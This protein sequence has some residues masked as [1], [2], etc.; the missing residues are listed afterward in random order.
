M[1]TLTFIASLFCWLSCYPQPAVSGLPFDTPALQ[2]LSQYKEEIMPT[3]INGKFY[4]VNVKTGKKAFV[5]GFDAAY[6]FGGENFAIVKAAGK[7]G[8]INK[9]GK[10][11]VSP[12]YKSFKICSPMPWD[13]VVT[14]DSSNDLLFDLDRGKFITRAGEIDPYIEPVNFVTFKGDDSRFGLKKIINNEYYNQKTLFE[15][16]FDSVYILRPNY[17]VAAR[18]GTIGIADGE[19]ITLLP[20]EY[21]E[22]IS[23]KPDESRAVKLIGLR[24]ATEWEYYRLEQKPELILRSAHQCVSL[25][26][27]TIPGALGV[28][29]SGS[30][31]NVLFR[32]GTLLSKDY[33]WI[34]NDATIAIDGNDVYIIGGDGDP[35]FYYK[36]P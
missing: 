18:E 10:Y 16:V 20:F 32:T 6:P 11:T 15:P 4:Y 29:K 13:H 21:D 17:F 31:Y 8:V 23:S 28:C 2:A 27:I 24:K 12:R 14:F 34:S 3:F 35:F 5:Q 22:I 36:K 1:R 30:K 19:G 26:D 33:D 25:G 7:Y 9:N